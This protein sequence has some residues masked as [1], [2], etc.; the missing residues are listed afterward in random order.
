MR[1]ARTP[2]VDHIAA[3]QVRTWRVNYANILPAAELAALDED[4]LAMAW[5]S[6]ILNPPTPTHRL[7]VAVADT[8]GTDVV[9]GYAAFGAGTDPDAN[10]GTAELL[11]LVVDP[12][13]TR[14]G[15]GSRLIAATVEQVRAS[16]HVTLVTWLPLADEITRGF[17]SSCGWGPDS[18]YRDRVISDDKI[19]R[20]VRLVTDIRDN[21]GD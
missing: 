3:L 5:A 17:L 7:M 16:G 2:D 19:L 6:A 8:L 11:A 15:H 13:H 12:G 1:P 21:S 10:P 14:L 4:E 18:A 9:V 20:E